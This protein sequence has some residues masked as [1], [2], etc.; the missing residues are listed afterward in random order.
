MQDKFDTGVNRMADLAKALHEGDAAG[1]IA[2]VRSATELG[3][4]TGM[5]WAIIV[6]GF[7]VAIG[8]LIAKARPAAQP[9][10]DLA[11]LRAQHAELAREA[12]A[13]ATAQSK[14]A[15]APATPP[16]PPPPAS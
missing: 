14:V 6:I 12:L 16:P 8:E 15:P 5:I 9:F 13:A 10:I 2:S 7:I 1:A 11:A 3:L 4:D